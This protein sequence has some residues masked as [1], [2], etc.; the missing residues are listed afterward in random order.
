MAVVDISNTFQM[1]KPGEHIDNTDV[2]NSNRNLLDNPWFGSGEVVNQRGV[3]SGQTTH[4]AY[5]VDRWFTSYGNALGTWSI[6]ANGL[7][8]SAASGTYCLM[9][10]N[11]P[12]SLATQLT[13][14]TVTC[15]YLTAGGDVRSGTIQSL[16]WSTNPIVFNYGAT[17]IQLM[18]NYGFRITARD[19]GTSETIRAV[20][21]ELGS[22]STLINDTPPNYYE[23]LDKCQYYFER[24]Q[25]RG[26]TTLGFGYAEGTDQLYIHCKIHPK[27]AL[28]TIPSTSLVV[29]GTTSMS[30]S[31]P[32][33]TV[34]T[35]A[36]SGHIAL[37]LTSTG[38]FNNGQFYR[39]GILNGGHIDFSADL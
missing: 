27:R 12:A 30:I 11:L 14:K 19:G 5:T 22:Y 13:G 17:R 24:I 31:V 6:G 15:S 32:Q 28:V 35:N 29:A 9:Q 36:D 37:R 26:H 3:T 4:A 20:K 39:G 16:D 21:L 34:Y 7:T 1:S 25:A 10:Q 8:L 23:E 18:S 38:N 33:V 2:Y